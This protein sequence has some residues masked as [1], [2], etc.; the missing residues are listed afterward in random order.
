MGLLMSTDIKYLKGVGPKLSSILRSRG[1][2]TIQDF[3]ECYPRA[4]EDRRAVRSIS[5]LKEGDSVSLRAQVVGIRSTSM[6]RSHRRIYDILVKD[7]TGQICCKYFRIPYK[8]YF[9]KFQ[10]GQSVR[11]IGKVTSYRDQL[12]FQHPDIHD[13]TKNESTDESI[14]DGLIPLYTDIEG[15]N[16]TK[17]RRLIS[18]L[19]SQ[20]DFTKMDPPEAD[21]QFDPKA[22]LII[23]DL[24]PEK[25][26]KKYDL[27]SRA[28]CFRQIHQ[29]AKNSDES[30]HKRQSIFHYRIIFE[31]FFWLELYMLSRK[32]IL[33]VQVAPKMEKNLSLIKQFKSKL[34]F[35]LTSAQQKTFKEIYQDIIQARPM[36]RLLQGDVGSGK[37]LVALMSVVFVKTSGYQSS[38]MVPTEILAEQHYK[39]AQKLLTDLGVRVALL[40]GKKT[41]KEKQEVLLAL[42]QGDIDLIIGTHALIQESVVFHNL[43]LV[44]I[45]EQHRFGVE[46]RGHLKAKGPKVHGQE[47]S[48]H[49]LVMTATPIPRTLSMTLYGDLDVSII[50]EMP[51]GRISISSRVAYESSRPKMLT[52]LSEQIRKGRQGYIIYPLVEDSE[53][54]DLKNAV[55][56]FDKLKQRFPDFRLELLH[57][58]IKPQEKED[59]MER[60]RTAQVD[61]LVS[62]TV[63]EVG[64][65][66]PNANIIIIEHCERFGLSQLHQLRGRVGRG[67]HKSFCILMLG[68]G[69]SPEALERVKVMESTDDGFKISEEDLRLRGPGELLGTRQSGLVNFKMADLILDGEILAKA[70]KAV[71][72]LLE[73]DSTLENY[74]HLKAQLLTKHELRS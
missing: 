53:H 16:S 23:T 49:F 72:E 21:S 73:E 62:T 51:K 52:F 46:Q 63:V 1:I 64:V 54:L 44:I 32:E 47:Q 65:D 10:P 24:I 18:H 13:V 6:G 74:P 11:I 41:N 27:P 15:L 67:S 56:E 4:Y 42:S 45:D 3:L 2:H 39:G 38:L 5:N 12:Q 17:M 8:G 58:R 59:I 61:I 36:Y 26:R 19:L 50:D 22:P 43:G 29:P 68:N 35:E 71:S 20:V 60:F 37:T 55:D 25:I 40:T 33:K 70:R 31:E 57:G 14:E 9:Q 48:P 69:F 7:S 28:E 66:V 30:F 34:E